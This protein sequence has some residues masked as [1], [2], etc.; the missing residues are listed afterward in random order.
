M[1]R[2]QDP[3]RAWYVAAVGDIPKDAVASL[4]VDETFEVEKK[5]S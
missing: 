4:A 5:P 1:H 2:G 3:D